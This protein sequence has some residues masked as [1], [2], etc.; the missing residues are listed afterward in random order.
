MD[1]DEATNLFE[2]LKAFKTQQE[3]FQYCEESLSH[4]EKEHYDYKTKADSTNPKPGPSDQKNLAK[5]LSGFSNSAG[6]VLI[7]G[8]EDETLE[9]RPIAQAHKFLANLLELAP[10]AIDPSI[11]G[12][13]G[14]VVPAD[15]PNGDA[16][17]VLLLI[18]ESDAPPHRVILKDREIQGHYYIRC[19]SSFIKASHSQLEDMFGR[20]PR[21]KLVLEFVRFTKDFNLHAGTVNAVFKLRNDGRGLARYPFVI[22]RLPEGARGQ[23]GDFQE[24][25]SDV[26]EENG[27]VGVGNINQ[28][29]IHPGVDLEIVGLSFRNP[30]FAFGQLIEL[31][32]MVSAEGQ[33]LTPYTFKT[34]FPTKQELKL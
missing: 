32:C 34:C 28:R 13:D 15:P 6:G 7:W 2:S 8:V 5:A 17:F 3:L 1:L 22:A 12:V 33:Q 10:N 11:Q 19:G 20:R 31:E 16:G 9:P 30:R 25:N 21:P 29:V 18:R 4:V 24:R 14:H 26:F 23:G 27:L